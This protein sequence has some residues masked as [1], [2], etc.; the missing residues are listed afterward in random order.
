MINRIRISSNCVELIFEKGHLS[1]LGASRDTVF[2]VL[3]F[4][5]RFD[6]GS[7]LQLLMLVLKVSSFIGIIFRHFRLPH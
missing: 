6:P 4:A 7:L 1:T 2:L 3:L 5:R